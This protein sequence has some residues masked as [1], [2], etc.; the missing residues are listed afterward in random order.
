MRLLA[1]ILTL[2]LGCAS[3]SASG[4]QVVRIWPEYMPA[5]SFVRISEYF[6][7]KENTRGATI[8]RTQP[9]ARDGFYFNLRTKTDVPIEMAKVVLEIIT[10]ASAET[11]VENFAVSL[12]KGSHILRLGLTGKDWPNSKDRPA[13]WKLR[14]LGANG[15]ELAMKQSYLWSKP[16]APSPVKPAET[17]AIKAD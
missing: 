6:N 10:P 11:R 2:T 15:A 7:G 17:S 5:D 13:A 16:D 1:L 8:L 9:N 4:V 12:P 14:I 3:V